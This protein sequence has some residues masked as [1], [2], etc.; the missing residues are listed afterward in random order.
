MATISLSVDI[1]ERFRIPPR[2]EDGKIIEIKRQ[3]EHEEEITWNWERELG[4]GAHG[5][6]WLEKEP[7]SGRT[8][9]VKSVRKGSKETLAHRKEL[10]A[11]SSLSKVL[12]FFD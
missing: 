10:L 2:F 9:A 3:G 12:H 4:Y 6:V 1:L 7:V 11:L 8:R 5:D